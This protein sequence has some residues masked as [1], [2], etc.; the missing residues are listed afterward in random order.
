MVQ[1]MRVHAPEKNCC[2]SRQPDSGRFASRG[3]ANRAEYKEIAGE[4]KPLPLDFDI[5]SLPLYPPVQAKLDGGSTGDGRENEDAASSKGTGEKAPATGQV[6]PEVDRQEPNCTGMPDSLKAGIEALSGINMSDV[7]VHAN[8]PK[9]A[10]LNAL[11]YTQGNQIYIAP[12]QGR[13]LAHEAWHVVQ[14]A[15]GRVPVTR[16]MKGVGLN[17]EVKLEREADVM[18]GRA[19]RMKAADAGLQD[20]PPSR[21]VVQAY[22]VGIRRR[23]D[24]ESS[25]SEEFL[26]T[27]I[28]EIE[29]ILEAVEITEGEGVSGEEHQRLTSIL[30]EQAVRGTLPKSS[31]GT[32][33]LGGSNYVGPFT[34]TQGTK[35]FSDAV[36]AVEAAGQT[37]YLK[38]RPVGIHD[39]MHHI[40]HFPGL[41]ALASSQAHCFFC[42]GAVESRGYQHGNIREQPWPKMWRHD[43]LGFQ[44][45]QT[46]EDL[47]GNAHDPAISITSDIF[48][49][50]YYFVSR[51]R[52]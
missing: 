50:R 36:S 13:H 15:E 12:G 52:V 14:Q 46:S 27:V 30:G 51:I 38:Q 21:Q 43:Y 9:P 3:F 2:R 35:N 20:L 39:E 32:Y 11:A 19:L 24:G 49:T 41:Q 47:L 48:G 5:M 34:T 44:L 18:A 23:P 45:T 17:D 29:R 37:E 10:K 16:Q 7:R 26:A 28:T 4:H 40:S 22:G 6:Q 8:S 25:V 1:M 42:F 31:A 33:G